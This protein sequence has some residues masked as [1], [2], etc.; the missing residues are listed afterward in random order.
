MHGLY[1]KHQSLYKVV[2]GDDADED[3]SLMVNAKA[4]EEYYRHVDADKASANFRVHDPRACE[5]RYSGLYPIIRE[6]L[7]Q[8]TTA[9]QIEE[10]VNEA[11]GGYDHL[12]EEN[13]AEFF[14]TVLF[15]E[16]LEI[17]KYVKSYSHKHC[18][19]KSRDKLFV[20]EVQ[21]E[22]ANTQFLHLGK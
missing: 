1:R 9:Q 14:H 20:Y 15:L 2:F 22:L 17:L 13:Y 7:K 10:C 4:L 11:M 3:S 16:E 19:L 18:P 5:P 6:S 8:A 12:N 21:N